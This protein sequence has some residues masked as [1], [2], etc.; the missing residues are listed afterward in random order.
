[1]FEIS[2]TERFSN[3]LLGLKDLRAKAKI[4]VRITRDRTVVRPLKHAH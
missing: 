3:W 1:M 4:L 2:E